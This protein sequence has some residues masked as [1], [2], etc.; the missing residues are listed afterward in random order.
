MMQK[1]EFECKKN[2]LCRIAG[3]PLE[4]AECI[5]GSSI[6]ELEDLFEERMK[7]VIYTSSRS[8]Y[9]SLRKGI[10]QENI[11]SFLK[12]L[13]R[14]WCRATPFGQLA[15]V[16]LGRNGTD[17]FSIDVDRRCSRYRVDTEWICGMENLIEKIYIGQLEVFTNNT[18][19]VNSY[20]V[21][22]EWISGYYSQNNLLKSQIIIKNNGVITDV[23]N[24]AKSGIKVAKLVNEISV[25][26][27]VEQDEVL[28]VIVFL[29]KEEFL[30]SLYKRNLLESD[31]FENLYKRFQ[32]DIENPLYQQL[33]NI[34]QGLTELNKEK[35]KNNLTDIIQIEK[36]LETL[37]NSQ[38][39]LNIDTFYNLMFYFYLTIK[40]FLHFFQI[41]FLIY[42]L[43]MAL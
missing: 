1:K 35:N 6:K 12:Y 28:K 3:Q 41:Y 25:R 37:F 32:W 39:Y 30:L 8:L 27:N 31:R 19:K 16:C 38:N 9:C 2:F 20:G 22:N 11:E 13:I 36:K 43:L 23:L 14:N 7:E 5:D 4:V 24:K 17:S 15:G 34:E 26:W 29:L 10:S 18:I 21:L 33:L 42:Q 40:H